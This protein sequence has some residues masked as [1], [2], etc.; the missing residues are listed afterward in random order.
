VATTVEINA[1]TT[2]FSREFNSCSLPNICSYQRRE[3]PPHFPTLSA[4]ENENTTT[5]MMGR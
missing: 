5:I 4:P 3:N 1:T 2:E